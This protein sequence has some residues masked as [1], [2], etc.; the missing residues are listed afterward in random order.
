MLLLERHLDR[1]AASAGY[2]DFDL[3]ADHVRGELADVAA[4]LTGVSKVRLLVDKQG[5]VTITSQPLAMGQR[6]LP[7]R[8][9]LA[10]EP[11]NSADRWLY[12]KTTVRHMYDKARASRP[13]CDDV[14]LWNERGEVTESSV[15]N[16]LV[17]LDGRW[18]TP[19]VSSGLLPGTMR[20]ALL[21]TGEI[22]EH[23]LQVADLAR[24]TQIVLI[25]SVRGRLPAL[26]TP[27]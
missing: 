26:W 9:G 2:F 3:D 24:A 6:P 10:A 21:A 18:F 17:E 5:Q 25:N 27:A 4:S 12:H 15:A 13:D 19:P 7:L 16:L 11:I 20:A 8:V 14:I 22:A 1:L 23:P